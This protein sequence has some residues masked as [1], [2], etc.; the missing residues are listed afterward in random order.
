[1]AKKIYLNVLKRLGNMKGD[2]TD[3]TDDTRRWTTDYRGS[4]IDYGR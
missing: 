1:M 2:D 3:I 4:P